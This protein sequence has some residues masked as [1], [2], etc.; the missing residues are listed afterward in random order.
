VAEHVGLNPMTFGQYTTSQ[1]LNDDN[2][3]KEYTI[4][5][6]MNPVVLEASEREGWVRIINLQF[7]SEGQ[8]I[9]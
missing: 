3:E 2:G 4:T 8:Q 6:L 1:R 7:D 5:D 9:N